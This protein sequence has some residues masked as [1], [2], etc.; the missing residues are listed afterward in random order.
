[1]SHSVKRFR[2]YNEEQYDMIEEHYDRR[3]HLKEKRLKA[4]LRSKAKSALLDLIDD[5]DF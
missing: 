4:A 2:K 1:M 5:E 3:E